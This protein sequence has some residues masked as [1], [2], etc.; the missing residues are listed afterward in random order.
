[1][2]VGTKS[3]VTGDRLLVHN[4]VRVGVKILLKT[5]APEVSLHS[6]TFEAI[7]SPKTEETYPPPSS[8]QM[9]WYAK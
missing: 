9:G 7:H 1:M 3:L 2:V 8:L 4:I 5:G 6:P